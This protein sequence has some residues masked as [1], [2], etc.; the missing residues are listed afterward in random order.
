VP[1]LDEGLLAKDMQDPTK[2]ELRI[3]WFGRAENPYLKGLDV[4]AEIIRILQNRK[5][6]G[7]RTPK[8]VVRGV[9]RNDNS[10][11]TFFKDIKATA[12]EWEPFSPNPRQIDQ[13]IRG[14]SCVIM[15][16]QTEAFGLVA[17]EAIAAGTPVIVSS[18]SG[19]G[20]LLL[21]LDKEHPGTIALELS[22]NLG[23][24]RVRRQRLELSA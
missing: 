11:A 9:D 4:A 24:G 17:L 16:S 10:V 23:D 14:A 12:Y 13:D 18:A 8:L 22:L 7:I 3:L 19:L 15:P 2:G 5:I 1:G 20:L 21:T 6:D